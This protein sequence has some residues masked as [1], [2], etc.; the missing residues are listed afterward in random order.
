MTEKPGERALEAMKKMDNTI[1]EFKKPKV[2]TTK[3]GQMKILTEEQYVEVFLYHLSLHSIFT[4]FFLS[5]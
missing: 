3:K 1:V 4:F 2:P 5:F